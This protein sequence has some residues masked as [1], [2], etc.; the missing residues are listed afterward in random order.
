MDI[1]Q[2]ISNLMKEAQ[3]MQKNMQQAQEELLK[4]TFI[5]KSGGGLVEI[6]LNG[7]YDITSLKIKPSVMDEDV[8][9]LCDLLK[10]AWSAATKQVEEMTKSKLTNLTAGLNIPKDLL[11]GE[12]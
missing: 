6:E 4:Q 9:M 12:K 8:E 3:K 7:R 11:N 5:G 10:A 1:N 2:N